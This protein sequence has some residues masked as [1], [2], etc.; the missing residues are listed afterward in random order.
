VRFNT[1]GHFRDGPPGN[2][3]HWYDGQQKLTAKSIKPTQKKTKHNNLLPKYI[4]THTGCK[5]RRAAAENMKD[6]KLRPK[7]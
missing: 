6:H 5:A 7:R 3:L 1:T 4:S 2:H